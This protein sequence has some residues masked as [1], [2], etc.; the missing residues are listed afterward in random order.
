MPIKTF[1]GLITD[2]EQE[3]IPLSTNTG[4]VG[5]KIVKFQCM[6]DGFGNSEMVIKI[7]A[8]EQ[9]AV[10]NN[11][12]FSDNTMLAACMISQ[13]LSGESNPEDQTIIF[14]NMVFN[15][16][17]YIT[18]AAS[19]SADPTNYYIELEQIKLDLNENTVA[20]LKDIRNIE[21]RL[22]VT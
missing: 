12:D 15:Q 3:T 8:V 13:S 4:A 2:G 17:I 1:R 9:L 6:A 5:Y 16:D 22:L 10:T 14:D 19:S 18:A 20:T 11:I 7:Y 21:A